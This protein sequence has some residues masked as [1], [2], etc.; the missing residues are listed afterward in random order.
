MDKPPCIHSWV[1][2]HECDD[3]LPTPRIVRIHISG[4]VQHFYTFSNAPLDDLR[5]GDLKPYPA[6]DAWVWLEGMNKPKLASVEGQSD[7]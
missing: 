5:L 4:V 7:G 3:S 1:Q 6:M 2:C